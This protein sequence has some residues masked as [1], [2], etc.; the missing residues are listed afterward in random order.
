MDDDLILAR[1]ALHTLQGTVTRR[2][3]EVL[4]LLETA[5]QAH[6]RQRHP[7]VVAERID[8]ARDDL[9]ALLAEV[10]RGR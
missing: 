5:A 4:A 8:A 7:A 10:Q 3:E 1:H 6:E 2:V 9:R